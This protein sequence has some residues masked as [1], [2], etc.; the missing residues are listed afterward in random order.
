MTSNTESE[1]TN[2]VLRLRRE[3]MLERFAAF[4]MQRLIVVKHNK[5][6]TTTTTC[7]VRTAW[8]IA[9]AMA[10]EFDDRRKRT[11]PGN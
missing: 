1:Q 3:Q 10:A 11:G 5:N 6:D 9:E 2:A 4:A 8:N 7:D